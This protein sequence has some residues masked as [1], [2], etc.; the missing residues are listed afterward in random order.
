M[1][2]ERQQ[3]IL[4]VEDDVN[5]GEML[6]AYFTVRGYRTQVASLG[7]FAVGVASD[8]Q[9]G[10]VILDIH[11]P[12]I[13][14]FEV[15]NRLRAG[16]KTRSIPILFLTEVRDRPDRLHGLELGVVDY[17]TKPFDVQELL[18]RVRNILRRAAGTGI[19]NPVTQLPEG[20][21]VDQMLE[22]VIAGEWGECAL[23]AVTL[24]GVETFRELYGFVASDDVLRVTAVTIAQSAL[25]IA[26]P[27]AFC[28]HLDA[29][30]FVIIAPT[31][32]LQPLIE[33]VHKR[34]DATLEYFYPGD[35]RGPTAWSGDRLRLWSGY[36]PEN[37]VFESLDDL[38]ESLRAAQDEPSREAQ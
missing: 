18:L 33:R 3:S 22:Q 7:E 19:E 25:E 14:G 15:C 37:T 8:E 2:E 30:T 21:E 31:E 34:L 9:P 10:L 11:L 20:G 1:D 13:D 12:D 36:L 5:L 27:G 38:K 23:V 35:N 6:S 17:I 29:Q 24:H 28:G 32:S 4:I 26:G 16:H